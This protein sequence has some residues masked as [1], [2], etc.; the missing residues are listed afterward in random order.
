LVQKNITLYKLVSSETGK[1]YI[2]DEFKFIPA[3]KSIETD[4]LSPLN[5][6]IATYQSEGNAL[7]WQICKFP[8]GST[9]LLGDAMM[10]YVSGQLEKEE[11]FEE[12]ENSI[13][14]QAE[15]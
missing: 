10:Q 11:L 4:T 2:V 3:F 15:K 1:R 13:I 9:N 7:T 6:S 8:A 12:M 14:E 5:E